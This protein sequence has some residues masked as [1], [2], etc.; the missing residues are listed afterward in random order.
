[1]EKLHLQHFLYVNK[2]EAINQLKD[3]PYHLD[4]KFGEGEFSG[5]AVFNYNSILSDFRKPIVNE[6]RGIILNMS[7]LSVVS[8]GFAKFY[9]YGQ[10]FHG[11][12]L[13]HE[14]D[15]DTAWAEEKIDGSIITVY[16]WNGSWRVKTNGT[17]NAETANIPYDHMDGISNFKQ[18][19]ERAVLN[20][21]ESLESFYN[22]LRKD[23]CYSFE[24][25]GPNNKIVVKYEKID[26]IFLGA[27]IVSSMQEI[28]PESFGLK[29]PCVRKFRARS[30]EDIIKIVETFDHEREG[31]VIVDAN[32][33]RIKI[34]SPEYCKVHGIRGEEGSFTV[35]KAFSLIL[36]GKE[37]DFSTLFPE[38]ISGFKKVHSLI[39][40]FIN[41]LNQDLANFLANKN[42]LLTR[43]E[44]ALWVASNAKHPSFIFSFVDGKTNGPYQFMISENKYTLKFFKSHS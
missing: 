42:N 20:Y 26:V 34:K 30:A 27:R 7:D 5:L 6:A 32:F 39:D 12:R 17:I 13:D 21:Y 40:L 36:E 37:D 8:C 31:F 14:I 4:V 38:F 23:I 18:Y 29:I 28:K 19:F 3:A 9:N 10:L 35:A 16:W 1:M 11:E 2:E 41:E 44:I 33:N 15:W 24:V 22:S 25:V 43:K